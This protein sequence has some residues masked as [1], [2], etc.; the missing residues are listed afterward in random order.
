MKP[1]DTTTTAG[2]F[3]DN[4]SQPKSKSRR[5]LL[6]IMGLGAGITSS[7]GLSAIDKELA[8]NLIKASGY[9]A[10]NVNIILY[11]PDDLL[12]LTLRFVGFQLSADKKN[13][14]RT[15]SPNLL[16]VHLHPQGIAEQAY[17][18]SGGS[19]EANFTNNQDTKGNEK[20]NIGNESLSFPAKTYIADRSRLVFEIPASVSIIELTTESLLNWDKFKP[21]INKR[22]VASAGR[23]I[24]SAQDNIGNYNNI[25]IKD[26]K[27]NPVLQPV[28]NKP[29]ERNKPVINENRNLKVITPARVDTAKKGR[30]NNRDLRAA[31][32][33]EEKAIATR[34]LPQE[35]VKVNDN[36]GIVAVIQNLKIGKTP[37][38]VDEDETAIEMPYR[39]FISPN[40]Y[41]AWFHEHKLKLRE[42]LQDS[43]VKTYELWHS[44]LTCRDCDDQK[45]NT[46]ATKAIKSVRA[47]WGTD[48]NGDYKEKPVR[49]DSYKTALYNDDR[50]CIV[51]ESSNW[52][53]D[54]F[55]PKPVQVNNLML[56]T[57]GAWFDAEML[58]NRKEL[59]RA[60]IIGDLNLLKWK[61]IATLARD[62]YVEV[63]YAGNVLPFGHEASLVRI[64]ERKPQQ[65]YAVNRQR[66]FVVINEE[67]KKY[68]PY[69]SSNG[70]FKSFNFS[71]IK[72]VTTVTSTID[73][74][75]RFCTGISDPQNDHQFIPK[76]G[77]KDLLFKIIGYDLEGNELSFE[78]PV[79]FVTTDV[80]YD[81]NG[82]YNITNIG[83]LNDC[84]NSK[85]I[86]ANKINFHNQQ[87]ALTRS[88]TE[89]DTTFEI[90]TITFFS[91]GT[92]E[93]SPGFRPWC[94]EL[95]I[96][97]SAVENI[98]GKRAA[99]RIELIDDEIN[100]PEAQRSNKGKVFA[101]L[102]DIPK[103]DFNGNGNK[104]GG[105]LSPNFSITALSKSLGAIGGD[106]NQAKA[107]NF[108]PSKFFD[109]S[110]KLFGVI[111]LGKII[112]AVNNASSIVNGAAVQSP[113]PALKNIETKEARITQF[114]WNAASL[115]AFDFG[116]VKFQPK[117]TAAGKIKVETNLYR[118][119]DPSK[120]TTL[121]VNSYIDDFA[122]IVA[123]I[124]AIDFK[125]VGFFTGSDSK[126][127][128]TVDMASQPFRFLGALTFVNDL[129]KYIPADGFSDPPFLDVTT[130]GVTAG[131]TLALPDIQ[132]GVFTLRHVNLGA[133]V[134]LPFTGAPL[135]LRFNFCE[136]QQPFT[137][138]VSALGGGGFFA[139]E[140][141]MH[142]LRT[143]EA[144][145]EFGAAVSLNL[146]V[147]SGAVSIMGGVYF[148][149]AIVNG[150]NEYE[151]QGY[152][153]INGAMS[154]L[155][156]VTVS[157]EF[158]LTL[159][160]ELKKINGEDKV[161]R[162]WGEASLKI[163]IEI[164]MFSKTVSVKTQREFAGA[165]A[166]PTFSMLISDNEWEQYC[167]SFA[168]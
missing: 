24:F 45:D 21:A 143:L 119:K 11:R 105:S 110:A 95:E 8:D 104:T 61:H 3:I 53:I 72:F 116:F 93:E 44:R 163:K 133:A 164:F 156:L 150:N 1:S 99:Q 48:I 32:K 129:Q 70:N 57:L 98:T 158:L 94:K 139:L 138:T 41:S 160:A 157:V 43:A 7:K 27:V 58:V 6:K 15:Q 30:V 147:A 46:N 38:P 90:Q 17:E 83:K 136:K 26:V 162:V 55:T 2:K 144:A 68:N 75:K 5:L 142:G 149:M 67:E 120:Q 92:L 168:A 74:P 97:I 91:H 18:E 20:S 112:K 84:Y 31:T 77:G 64:T 71:T 145:L 124:A 141:D 135:T 52:G 13:I 118:Y 82:N 137:L 166:D 19:G 65:G 161:S 128:F 14:T 140:L 80:T 115:A 22:A 23:I 153:R 109:S 89:G 54:K 36:A 88:D 87:M 103:V 56:S 51:H 131:F 126:V 47:L 9:A 86:I 62:H 114:I 121:T 25:L 4:S 78:M 33:E 50:H 102:L 73:P 37:R 40:Q 125:R 29:P 167:D 117:S 85:N 155:G 148:K 151:L 96:F 132:L 76:A 59:E 154:V 42:D 107:S 106:M 123:G 79:V 101:K 34:R 130:S 66:Y 63:V 165:G 122:V 159:A 152:V 12:E 134:N 108:D 35:V 69:N 81:S 28:E 16:I 39:L 127:D 60:N 100:K 113:F 10:D 111:E 146:G 49:N